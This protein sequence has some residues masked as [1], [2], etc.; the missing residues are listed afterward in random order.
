MKMFVVD[1]SPSV[2]SRITDQIGAMAEVEIV[3]QAQ[4]VE[5][6][7]DG[8]AQTGPDVVLL[9]AHLIDG[10]APHLLETLR[11]GGRI[12]L[13]VVVARAPDAQ[14]RSAYMDMGADY[15]LDQDREAPRILSILQD[16]AIRESTRNHPYPLR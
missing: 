5:Q 3:G 12:P 10:G 6:A 4:N 15:V 9:Q 2:Q 14:T 13:V 11:Q 1:D 8:I 7:K 16:L